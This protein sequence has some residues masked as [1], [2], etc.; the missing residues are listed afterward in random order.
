MLDGRDSGRAAGQG[1]ILSEQRAVSYVSVLRHRVEAERLLA[2]A[3][4]DRLR[5]S[6]SA[7]LFCLEDALRNAELAR[8]NDLVTEVLD[9]L[10][11]F[12]DARPPRGEG[13]GA[14][15]LRHAALRV[16]QRLSQARHAG[17]DAQDHG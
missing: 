14:L 7:S 12:N 11:R 2:L 9:E 8:A 3:R 5:K 10:T 6:W 4:H 16:Q 17:S 13:P 1:G 15:A